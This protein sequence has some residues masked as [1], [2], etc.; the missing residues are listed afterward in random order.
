M[1]RIELIDKDTDGER[2]ELFQYDIE[3][4]GT[5]YLCLDEIN[6]EFLEESLDDSNYLFVHLFGEEIRGFACVYLEDKPEKHLY[7]NLIC[8]SKFHTMKTRISGDAKRFGGKNII[9][10]IKRLGEKLQVK[11]IKL[12][13]INNVISYYYSIGFRFEN[14]KLQREIETERQLIGNLRKAQIQ[15]YDEEVERQLDIIVGRFYPGFYSETM[16]RKIGEGEEER[17]VVAR[18]DGIPMIY[19]LQSN[20]NSKS[21][22]IGGT[23]KKKRKR[24]IKQTNNTR[25]AKQ[26]KYRQNPKRNYTQHKHK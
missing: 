24:R 1:S 15:G 4:I 7:V 25:Q 8:N 22:S 19:Y 9:D 12:N 18:E 21:K 13:A 6:R 14:S 5:K 2:Y 26:T 11:Y 20:S 17:K 10:E 23:K 16:Q 3:K